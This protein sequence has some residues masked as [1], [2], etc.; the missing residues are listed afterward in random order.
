MT[1]SRTIEYRAW[2]APVLPVLPADWCRALHAWQTPTLPSPDVPTRQR[3][4]VCACVLSHAC[5]RVSICVHRGELGRPRGSLTLALAF[6]DCGAGDRGDH[7]ATRRCAAASRRHW[8]CP[9]EVPRPSVRAPRAPISRGM[10]HTRSCSRT[11]WSLRVSFSGGCIPPQ[12]IIK[13]RVL[14]ALG[15]LFSH[16][17]FGSYVSITRLV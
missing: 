11:A 16:A 7:P 14:I 6:A 3:L 2:L 15:R 9:P 8:P 12:A 10:W 5:A 13:I 4:R 1:T 17:F